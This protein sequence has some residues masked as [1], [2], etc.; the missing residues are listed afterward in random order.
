MNKFFIILIL[1]LFILT[2][3]ATTTPRQQ[4]THDP[5]LRNQL[6][7]EAIAQ[8]GV[9]YVFGGTTT[10]GFDCSGLVQYVYNQSGLPVPRNSRAQYKAARRIAWQDAQPGDLLFFRLRSSSVSH[11]G[12]YVG[13]GRFIHA[14][15]TGK[16]VG[17]ATLKN[18]FWQK[19]L[20]S[21]GRLVEA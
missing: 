6:V 2:G 17:W 5:E 16:N 15:R 14:P 18:R 20:V 7:M 3:C 4:Y 10:K 8:I 21:A 11:V 1:L 13:N 9:P 19:R 12:I